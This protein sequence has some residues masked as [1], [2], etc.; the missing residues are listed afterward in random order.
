MCNSSTF[1]NEANTEIN[2]LRSDPSTFNM[3]VI[4]RCDDKDL[5]SFHAGIIIKFKSDPIKNRTPPF[6]KIGL[7][8]FSNSRMFV[9]GN[10]AYTKKTTEG[11]YFT[12]AQGF[13]RVDRDS[14]SKSVL[15]VGYQSQN[16]NLESD[17]LISTNQNKFLSAYCG[18][19][20]IL[21]SNFNGTIKTGY[22]FVNSV[23]DYYAGSSAPVSDHV[24]YEEKKEE[25][26]KNKPGLSFGTMINFGVEMKIVKKLRFFIEYKPGYRAN[27][28][29]NYQLTGSNIYQLNCGLKFS[30]K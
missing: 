18:V 16:I 11:I 20:A 5:T 17:F 21:G 15:T 19:S 1:F 8:Y 27:K 3:P 9:W 30:S 7:N 25:T 22:E 14:I 28:I 24:Y 12:N 23:S 2:K 6:L 4:G 10:G 13:H 29:S 26:L